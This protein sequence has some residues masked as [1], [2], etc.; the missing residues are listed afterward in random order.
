MEAQTA[1]SQH[2]GK[3]QEHL[4]TMKSRCHP[5]ERGS[6]LG[7][8]ILRPEGRG[9]NKRLPSESSIGSQGA[10]HPNRMPTGGGEGWD[11]SRL[12]TRR[13]SSFLS[14]VESRRVQSGR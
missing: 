3:E 8:M 14:A 7:V 1:T 12:Y 6:G 4:H 10:P 9:A 13:D 5:Q 2:L 11:T